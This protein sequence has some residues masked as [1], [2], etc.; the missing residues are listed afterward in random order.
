[1]AML[2]T[3]P[4]APIR[5]S[6][7]APVQSADGGRLAEWSQTGPLAVANARKMKR[8]MHLP[9][10]RQ[11]DLQ[12]LRD[13]SPPPLSAIV[14]RSVYLADANGCSRIC[15]AGPQALEALVC[16]CRDGFSD[17]ECVR[18]ATCVGAD[19]ARD[20]LL[21]L[22]PAPAELLM[23]TIVS[24]CRL[25]RDGGKLV[26]RRRRWVDDATIRAALAACGM[27]IGASVVDIETMRSLVAYTVERSPR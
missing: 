1:M 10:G 25:L 11:A 18:Q 20:L 16:L 3:K 26:I 12:I 24:T 15:T 5:S 8:A 7:N 4:F 19:G 17:V 23:S 27:T 22:G 6:D 21:I 9:P 13:S 14:R 2:R